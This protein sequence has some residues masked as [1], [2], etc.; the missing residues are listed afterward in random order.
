MS[1]KN[2][3]GILDPVHNYIPLSDEMLLLIDL[4]IFQRL[5]FIKQL[6][7]AHYVYSG[8]RHS[9]KEH[10]IGASYLAR[11]YGE[12]LFYEFPQQ[13]KHKIILSLQ[14]SAL[15]HDAAHG[16]MS[17]AW[18]SAIYSKIYGILDKGHDLKRHDILNFYLEKSLQSMGITCEDIENIWKSKNKLLG[19]IMNGPLSVDR[20][21][22]VKR[23]VYYT[24]TSHFGI[25]DMQRVI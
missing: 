5:G 12:H 16:V 13:E 25:I 15:F 11:C 14:I 23:D 19:A 3:K 6:S 21:D 20:G 9:R 18:D 7:S 10:C 22:F 4:P 17:H 1:N 24:G 2:V 8:A